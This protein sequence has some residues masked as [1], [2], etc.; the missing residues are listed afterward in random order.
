LISLSRAIPSRFISG[1]LPHLALT[2]GAV[3]CAGGKSFIQA[4]SLSV[5]G[6]QFARVSINALSAILPSPTMGA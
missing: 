1:W 3:N 6:V 5:R 2:R 4:L